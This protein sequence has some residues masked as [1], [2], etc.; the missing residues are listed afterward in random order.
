METNILLKNVRVIEPGHPQNGNICDVHVGANGATLLGPDQEA[1][2]EAEVWDGADGAVC[3]SMGWWD[4]QVDFGEPGAEEREGMASGLTAAAAGGFTD[5][6]HVSTTDPVVDSQADVAFLIRQAERCEAL[7]RLHPLGTISRG[8]HGEVLSDMR[9]LLAAGAVGFSEDGS[10]DSP[11]LLRRALEYLQPLNPPVCAQPLENSLHR[12][13]LMHE[14]LS[15][16]LMGLQGTPAEAETMRLKR[17]LDILR[18]TGGHLHLPVVT[19]AAACEVIRSA[20]AEGLHITCGTSAFHLLFTDEDLVTF[21]GTL[22]VMPP[23]RSSADREAL[24]E[25]IWDGTIDCVVSDH[26]PWNLERHDVEFMLVPFGIAGVD[27]TFPV[28]NAALAAARPA[29]TALERAEKIV[30]VLGTGPRLIFDPQSKATQPSMFNPGNPAATAITLFALED[31]WA[32]RGHS[33]AANQ[34]DAAVASKASATAGQIH[35]I[36]TPQGA[37]KLLPVGH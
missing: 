29:A 33:Q 13:A 16:T 36:I 34:P 2:A 28:L 25:A 32:P 22:K 15:S 18:Y 20:K 30:E 24:R 4:G 3:V 17:D 8:G 5:V 6:V 11:E 35:G 9:E 37:L 1:P 7:T 12:H 19:T 23:F 10:V 31:S 27:W 26:R 21:D 14:G